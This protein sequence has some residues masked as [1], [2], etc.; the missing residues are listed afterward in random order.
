VEKI[1]PHCW[2]IA[3]ALERLGG[4]Q[5]LLRK[6]CQ[7]FQEECPKLVKKLRVAVRAGDAEETLRAARN[8]KGELRY[9]GGTCA[10]ETAGELETMGRNQNLTQAA[11]KLVFL[12][13]ELGTLLILMKHAMETSCQSSP[14]ARPPGLGGSH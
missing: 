14:R 10:A 1:N 6:L 8:L 9:L 2:Q 7:I 5:E 12:E 3:A 4:D 11:E 13:N